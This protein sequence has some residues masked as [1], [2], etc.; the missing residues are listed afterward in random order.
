MLLSLSAVLDMGSRSV[1]PPL[2]PTQPSVILK[3]VSHG[4]LPVKGVIIGSPW[5]FQLMDPNGV[6]G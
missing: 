6:Q 3:T 1:K 5:H 4:H 2:N